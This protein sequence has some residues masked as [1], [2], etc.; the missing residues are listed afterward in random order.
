MVGNRWNCH[1]NKWKINGNWWKWM[2]IWW[3]TCDKNKLEIN[4]NGWKL[5]PVSIH[6]N[7]FPVDRN[8]LEMEIGG[9]E[10]KFDKNWCK[11]MIINV[12]KGSGNLEENGWKLM[13][14]G[15]KWVKI[16]EYKEIFAQILSVYLRL[17]FALKN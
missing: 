8:V 2:Q 5:H 4:S 15:W 14:L 1:V 11:L 16:D 10:W 12:R 13:K 7:L 9:N 6:L 3:W 17:I